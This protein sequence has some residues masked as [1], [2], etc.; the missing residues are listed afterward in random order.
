M[1]KKT[2]LTVCAGAALLGACQPA[3]QTTHISGTLTGVESDTVVLISSVL[4]SE[5]NDARNRQDTIALQQG[6]FTF[7]LAADSLPLQVVIY[8]KP[9]GNQALN[10]AQTA[11]VVVFPGESLTING[12][13]DNYQVE[14]SVFHR[15]LQPV[16]DAGRSYQEKLDSL[17]AVMTKL[18]EEQSEQAQE[19][20]QKL[21]KEI[22]RPA[23]EQMLETRLQY[24]RQHPD[25][26]V[27]LYLLTMTGSRNVRE[28]LPTLSDKVKNGPLAALYRSLNEGVQAEIAREEAAKKIVEGAAAPD[29]T[30]NDLQGNPL[31]LSSLRGKYVVLDFWGSWCGWCIKGIPDMKKYYAK[32]KDKMEILGIDCRDTEEKWKAAVEKHELPWLHVY[33]AGDPDVSALYGIQGYPTKIVVDPEGKIAKV[34]VGEDPAFY[35]YL[36]QLFK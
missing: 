21:Y 12:S 13:L 10:Y 1:K 9:T 27:S 4:P 14:G 19:E 28:L 2:L 22:Y 6:A 26:D 35:E 33:N 29:F 32:Y 34:V 11:S 18:D 5:K 36:D 16:L 3:Q 17:S 30:L 8:A 24:I 7:E 25:S 31:A 15:E 23:L 20:I